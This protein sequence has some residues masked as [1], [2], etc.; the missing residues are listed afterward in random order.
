V[1]FVLDPYSFPAFR[2]FKGSVDDKAIVH[3]QLPVRQWQDDIAKTCATK[4]LFRAEDHLNRWLAS[5]GLQK[6]AVVGLEQI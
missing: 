2:F 3:F 1:K 6:G 5:R 4:L